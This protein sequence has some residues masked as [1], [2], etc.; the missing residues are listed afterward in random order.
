MP[1]TSAA[2]QFTITVTPVNDAPS[3]T[4]G[5]NQTVDEDA[6]AQTV[7][8]ATAISAGPADEAGQVL[9][10]N[11]SSSDTTLFAAQPAIDGA[12]VLTYTP[13]ADK[14]G[15]AT[16]SVSLSDN[17]GTA[18]GGVDTSAA[19][20]S[21]SRSRVSTTRRWSNLSSSQINEDGSATGTLS[22]TDADGDTEF[23]YS[24]SSPP[25]DGTAA[26]SDTTSGFF[27]YTPNADF[28][29]G[30]QFTVTVTDLSGGGGSATVTITITAQND[31]PV[32]A[33]LSATTPE[34]TPIVTTL[35]AIDVD[36]D[37]LTYSVVTVQPRARCP[38]PPPT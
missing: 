27:T 6:G 17:G 12:G 33:P 3:F 28:N 29:G 37:A 26:F 19:R 34:D 11:V 2:S 13:A 5:G 32:A 36:G 23:T 7:A 4:A 24:V 9:T 1:D 30:D 10:F 25:S 18:D 21:T 31:T 22:V 16:I 8:W 15:T 20:P 14:N 38:G 35:T